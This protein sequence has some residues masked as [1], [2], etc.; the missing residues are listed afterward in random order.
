MLDRC[1]LIHNFLSDRTGDLDDYPVLAVTPINWSEQAKVKC[2]IDTFD[3]KLYDRSDHQLKSQSL[4]GLSRERLE[5]IFT[6]TFTKAANSPNKDIRLIHR[7][8]LKKGIN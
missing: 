4:S 3:M 1:Q 6:E 7:D 5:S 8:N 2:W